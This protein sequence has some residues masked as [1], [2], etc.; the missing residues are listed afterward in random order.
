MWIFKFQ[1]NTTAYTHNIIIFFKFIV[2][3]IFPLFDFLWLFLLVY[4]RCIQR[5]GKDAFLWRFKEKK[6]LSSEDS[7]SLQ[8][9]FYFRW[10]D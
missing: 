1:E 10:A 5:L 9:Y 8:R 7:K 6:I 2:A 3:L 4:L